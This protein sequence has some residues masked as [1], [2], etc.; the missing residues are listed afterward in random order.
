MS[1]VAQ[2]IAMLAMVALSYLSLT[3]FGPRRPTLGFT[4]EE[5]KS[6]DRLVRSRVGTYFTIT[7]AVGVFVGLANPFIFFVGASKAFG[8]AI[9]I[10]CITIAA[11]APFTNWVTKKLTSEARIAVLLAH[12]EQTGAVVASLFWTPDNSGRVPVARIV[13]WFSLVNIAALTWLEFTVFGEIARRLLGLT[14]HSAAVVAMATACAIVV[15]FTLQYGIRGFVFIDA[16]QSPV[17]L[18]GIIVLLAGSLFLVIS[19]NHVTNAGDFIRMIAAP[20]AGPF[21]ALVF[22]VHVIV[23]NVFQVALTEPHWLRMWSFRD[24]E[25]S[26]QQ[27]SVTAAAVVWLLLIAMGFCVFIV[28]GRMGDEAF[29][30]LLRKLDSVSPAFVTLFWLAAVSAMFSTADAQVY[31][32]VLVS[33]FD[34]KKGSLSPF[35]VTRSFALK[36]ALVTAVVLGTVYYLTLHFSLPVTKVLFVCIPFSLNLLPAFLA[37]AL[38]RRPSTALLLL[39]AVLYCAVALWGLSQPSDKFDGTLMAAFVPALISTLV[40]LPAYKQ[41]T[42]SP[43]PPPRRRK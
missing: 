2:V 30:E 16:V 32:F 43:G 12:P 11:S 38:D 5:K 25:I 20:G 33:S 31:S 41:A 42:G 39:S 1:P 7:A 4:S 23:L 34:Y 29:P 40:W 22:V 26:K 27:T 3:A 24:K 13:K 35:T 37:K 14:S 8:L 15:F 10:C 36:R 28:T 6:W 19:G 18:L 17:M 21:A 9:F